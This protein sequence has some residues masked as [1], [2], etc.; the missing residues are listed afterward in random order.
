MKKTA[1]VSGVLALVFGLSACGGQSG[2]DG[3]NAGPSLF[4]NT[5]EL[6]RAASA[7]TGQAQSA[8][9]TMNMSMGGQEMTASGEGRF[10]GSD[11]AMSM[12]MNAAGQTQEMRIVGKVL[13]LKLPA[14]AQ[15]ATGGKPWATLPEGSEAAKQLGVSMEQ[16][17]SNNPTESLNQIQK[18]GT[19]TRGEQTTL[20]GQQVSHYWL[21]IDVA[22]VAD[23]I[24]GTGMP[25]E[26]LDRLK[27][28]NVTFPMELWLNSDQLPVQITEDLG[29]MMKAVGAPA[30]AQQATIKM[31]YTDWGAPVTVE[32]PP[33]DQV[34]E[35]K[36]GG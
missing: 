24:A 35:L 9:F 2:G 36:I 4:G 28:M 14:E 13:Y 29:P 27:S 6:V 32:A 33:A 23:E 25:A 18:A 26:M 16:A 15:A 1:L 7:K 21:N 30:E 11:T 17:E 10:A 31:K 22:K 8:K 5:Q 12:T 34:G 20:D 19:I 3:G